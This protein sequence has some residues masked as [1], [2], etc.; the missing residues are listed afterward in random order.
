MEVLQN[1]V[2]QY[3]DVSFLQMKKGVRCSSVVIVFAYGAMGRWSGPLWWTDWAI[4]RSSQC[5]TT[6]VTKAVICVILSV[7]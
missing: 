5:P 1:P 4:S 6:G 2:L 7:G 3:C